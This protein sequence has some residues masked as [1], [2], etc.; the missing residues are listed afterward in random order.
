M[1]TSKKFTF[2]AGAISGLA[3]AP[4]FFIPSLLAISLLCHQ[5][6]RAQNWQ[7]SSI[8][9]F[10]FGFGHFLTSMYWISI[11]V[12]VYIDE[13]WWAIPFALFGLPIIL[14]GFIATTCG[15]AFTARKYSY[16]QFIFCLSWVFCE[17]LR[18]WLF[19][20]LPWNL[21][22]YVITFSDSLIQ[23]VSVVGIYGL[24][25]F[26]VYIASSF[27]P[28]FSKEWQVP[29]LSLR[30]LAL[31][32]VAIQ[33]KTIKL[34]Y[35]Y[36]FLLDCGAR[37]RSLA[38]TLEGK[39]LLNSLI[40]TLLIFSYGFYRLHNH[41]SSFSNIKIRLV[42]PSIAQAAKWDEKAFWQNLDLQIRLSSAPG[43]VDLIIWSE[44]ALVVPYTY[45][46]VNSK[47]LTMLENK[48]AIL[49]TGGITS[50]EQQ[51]DNFEIY[52][53]LYALNKKGKQLFEYHKSHLVPF[54]E[55]MP[56]KQI[57]PLKKLTPGLLDYTAG[58]G[59]VVNLENPFITIKPLI[60]YEAIF[61]DFVRT[62][63]KVADL[64]INVTN[65]AWY[66]R[67]VGPYQHLQISRMR[68]VENG[69]PMLRT[70]NNGISAIIDPVGRII[71]FLPLNEVG[72]IDHLVP[73]KLK[74]PTLYS[75]W[76]DICALLAIMITLL[77]YLLVKLILVKI[78]SIEPA[79]G[80][81]SNL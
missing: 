81:T 79:A 68:S 48:E 4:I 8:I 56:L 62:S 71:Q 11:G 32:G 47:L 6:A 26:T 18:S 17:W 22:G 37:M 60:C 41:P 44:A 34:S 19:T 5:V 80:L 40:L 76:G 39:L 13:F 30:G 53:S 57:L 74:S 49:I 33:N 59:K 28:I 7:E 42:Q 54:G 63:N 21:L 35:C 72:Y 36:R 31:E 25:F 9:G 46:A 3:F 64:I 70:A 2:I 12:T 66:G 27:Y 55:Y 69:L 65:D 10:I 24:S 58:D 14:G 61:P 16:Y 75:Q 67:S 51:G 1:L 73:T 38:M 43:K 15:L 50:N 52:T 29:F 45:E 20:G 23:I 77:S 78:Y